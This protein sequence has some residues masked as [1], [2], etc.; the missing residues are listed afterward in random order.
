MSL[1]ALSVEIVERI[2]DGL[3][4]N[5][6]FRLALVSRNCR[7]GAASRIFQTLSVR[8]KSRET[9]RQN[10]GYADSVL[11][12]PMKARQ[13]RHLRIFSFMQGDAWMQS[14]GTRNFGHEIPG[15]LFTDA[16]DCERLLQMMTQI[17]T[18]R[19]FTWGFKEQI[20]P[21][22]LRL[23]HECSPRIRLHMPMLCLRSL[24]HSSDEPIC[25][26]PFELELATSPCL[27]SL[28]QASLDDAQR[29]GLVDYNPSAVLEM[30]A[31]AAPSLREVEISTGPIQ[32]LSGSIWVLAAI[33]RNSSASA[34]HLEHLT[35]S[36][37]PED[38]MTCLQTLRTM[39]DFSMLRSLRIVNPLSA[40]Q[41]L[42]LTEE[43]RFPSLESLDFA[44]ADV[45]NESCLN[46]FL[47]S[48]PPLRSLKLSG[49][50]F[51]STV[52]LVLGHSGHTL[53]CLHLSMPL[54][55]SD[56]GTISRPDSWA[57]AGAELIQLI[58][59]KAPSI[60]DLALCIQRSAGDNKE[61]AIYRELGRLASLQHLHLIV[62]Q[63]VRYLWDQCYL[64]ESELASEQY[65]HESVDLVVCL[66]VDEALVESIFQTVLSGKPPR[67]APLQTLRYEVA[68]LEP[69]G[70]FC[71]DSSWIHL[72]GYIAH[73]FDCTRSL[74]DDS[75]RSYFI[76][77][78][79]R[80]P[81]DERD[82]LCLEDD[83]GFHQW[84]DEY[85]LPILRKV[86]PGVDSRNWMERW[87]SLPLKK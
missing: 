60:E 1:D 85:S 24:I 80:E 81:S 2:C 25:I 61:V 3:D 55:Y 4:R 16:T 46:G 6:I 86:W 65:M 17:T 64:F 34:S 23:L 76:E 84:V 29:Q 68:A 50:Y 53:R 8:F 27:Y 13:V 78:Y 33:L 19:D 32:A 11:A 87:H 28:G 43:C 49:R 41:V 31:G 47:L 66:A 54:Q 58:Q 57:L 51:P 21:S 14:N 59:Q 73:S 56:V 18:L 35:F 36:T 7:I 20:P 74:R 77:E 45:Y 79:Q 82:R 42:W 10:C 44:P 26:D 63:P 71:S 48:L 9:F 15:G 22:I 30:V 70:G 62:Y 52:P 67:A 40:S 5:S 69:L 38:T 72:L 83:D 37:S 75:P 39:M 12:S